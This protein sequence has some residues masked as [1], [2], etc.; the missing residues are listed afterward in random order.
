MPPLAQE[1]TEEILNFMAGENVWTSQ[2]EKGE[3]TNFATQ[4]ML[5]NLHKENRAEI[6]ALRRQIIY[7]Q[8]YLQT[9]YSLLNKCEVSL[10]HIY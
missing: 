10:E 5:K 4:E 1:T 6:N 8:N 7:L 3:T 2:S 9:L